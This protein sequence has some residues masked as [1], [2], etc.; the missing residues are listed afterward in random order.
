MAAQVGPPP[1]G[2]SIG[3]VIVDA[4]TGMPLSGAS[5]LLADVD[6]GTLSGEDGRYALTDV[7]PGP[8]HMVVRRLGYRSRTL[9]VF[10]P[11]TGRLEVDVSIE[12]S[13]LDLGGMRVTPPAAVRGM[14][15]D[16]AAPFPDRGIG[17]AALA[18]H[19]TLALPDPLLAVTGGEVRAEPEAPTGLSLRGGAS[20]QTSF[21]LDGVPLLNP[22][23]AAGLFGAWNADATGAVVVA[24]AA[25]SFALPDALSGTVSALTRTPAPR[26]RVQAGLSTAEAR[27]TADGPTGVAGA[28]FLLSGRTGLSAGLGPGDEA[29]YLDAE[30]ADL[31][32]RLMVPVLGGELGLLVYDAENEIGAASGVPEDSAAGTAAPNAFS[33]SSR[34]AG[35]SW[36]RPVPGSWNLRIVGWR[37]GTD[38]GSSWRP[39]GVE[40]SLASRRRDLGALVVVDRRGRGGTTGLGLRYDRVGTAYRVGGDST[41]TPWE[42]AGTLDVLTGFAERTQPLASAVMAWAG[43]G[44]AVAGGG[45]RVAPRARVR[46]QATGRLA[47][48][49]AFS[50]THQYAQ[51]LRNPESV[52]GHVF[53]ADLFVVA[54]AAGVPVA[55]SD[56]VVLAGEW[57]AA[58]GVRIGAQGFARRFDDIVLAAPEETGPFAAAGFAVGEGSARGA[59]LEVT[60]AGERYGV[61]VSYAAQRV[62]IARGDSAYA[63]RLGTGHTLDAGVIV[64]PTPTM[65]L[66]VAAIAAAGRVGTG[67]AGP[68][69]W[70]ACNVVDLGC[71]FAGSPRTSGP[72][73]GTGLPVYL[74]LDVGGR[75]HWHVN[76]RGRDVLAGVFATLTNVIGRRN[77]LAYVV[78]PET[79]ERRPIEMLPRTPLVAGLDVRF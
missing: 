34:S 77:T 71:E 19:P 70:E 58:P 24:G 72:P 60:A 52:V 1:G 16:T 53:P 79:G 63:P 75:R 64:F 47:W 42:A 73:G 65:S 69:E 18:N 35:A 40:T 28:S 62:R 38:A 21:V 20:D 25:P 39:E 78:D 10:V 26:F 8:Q 3:G 43:M 5:I 27:A 59:A 23:H 7:A 14:D 11:R 29:S 12:P 50:R 68:F 17:H 33:W 13:P 66:R 76:V 32:G 4:G 54:G 56:Q 31:L 37:A 49:A 45:L 61:V 46:W 55:R 51:S 41:V 2:A 57:A 22:Y 15:V 74:R 36:T 67:V 44:V 30:T 9:H 48:S 6:R